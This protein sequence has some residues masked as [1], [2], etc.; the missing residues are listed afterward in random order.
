[1]VV[2]ESFAEGA[3]LSVGRT[4]FDSKGSLTDGVRRRDEGGGAVTEVDAVKTSV[5]QDEAGERGGWGIEFGETGVAAGEEVR[6]GM[7]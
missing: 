7:S 4:N 3:S 5:G 6:T 2:A 1:M